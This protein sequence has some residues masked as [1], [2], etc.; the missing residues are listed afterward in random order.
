MINMKDALIESV[1]E[2]FRIVVL[3]II[4]VLIAQLESGVF[5]FKVLWITAALA[6]LRAFDKFLHET[7]KDLKKS[8]PMK[9]IEGG[10]TRF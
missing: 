5:D 1:K 8:D 6:F 2:F 4:P 9:P 7:G 3:S 10:L